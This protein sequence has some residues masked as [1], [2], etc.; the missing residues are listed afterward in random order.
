MKIFIDVD[1]TIVNTIGN[2]YDKSTPIQE[3]IDKANKLYD[4]GHTITYW[5]ARGCKSGK[6]AE[7][8]RLTYSQLTQFGAK[9]HELRMGKPHFDLFI[10]D[11]NINAIDGWNDSNIN[12][13]L[14]TVKENDSKR[15]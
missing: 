12:N 11:K 13:I 8:F 5:T 10:D 9:F 4:E 6:T 14:N 3:N 1:N 15:V 7:Y 2:S